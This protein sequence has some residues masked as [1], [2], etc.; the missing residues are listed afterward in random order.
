MASTR[1]GAMESLIKQSHAGYVVGDAQPQS[2]AR[3]IQS[4]ITNFTLAQADQIHKSVLAYS[5]SNVATAILKEY[6]TAIRHQ[7]FE[8]DR[9]VV[10]HASCG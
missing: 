3:G 10:A 9:L 1:V 8:D 6:E 7:S 5:W 2:L 4:I